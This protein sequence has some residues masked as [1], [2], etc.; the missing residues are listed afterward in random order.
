MRSKR[1]FSQYTA[2]F[3]ILLCA[4]VLVFSGITSTDDEQL[5]VVITENLAFGKDYSA[6]PLFGND[7]LQGKAGGVEPLHPII[8]IPLY[9]LADHFSLG[10]VQILY[11]LPALTTALTGALLVCIAKQK[12]AP[13]KTAAV[14]GLSY[15]LGT[16]ALPYARMNFREPLAALL[17]TT[18]VLFLE[19]GKNGQDHIWKRILYP[20]LSLISLGL[21]ALTKI[22]A[23]VLIPF[24]ILSYLTQK[25]IWKKEGRA[26]M[27]T[28]GLIGMMLLILAG[29][30]L[31][32]IL[33]ADS[34][35]RFTLRF[36]NYIRYTLPRLPHDHFWLAVAGLLFSPGKGLFIY[37]PMLI[38]S[39][40][41]PFLKRTK[42]VDWVT[43][44]SALLGLTAVQ[45]LIYNDQWWGITWGTRAHIP[46]LPLTALAALPALDAGLNHSN[47]KIRFGMISLLILGGCVQIGRLLVSDPVYANW[48]VQS[49]SRE[50][51]A[52]TQWN[53]H[54]MP[55]HR[56]WWLAL[57]GQ[58]SDIAWL[59]IS[60]SG[61]WLVIT[62]I[63]L[64]LIGISLGITL[65]TKK[66]KRQ[67]YQIIVALVGVF[68]LLLTPVSA[69]LDQR[70]Y[71]SV[72]AFEDAASEVCAVAESGDLVLIDAYLKPFWWFYINF[73][74]SGP[75][76]VGLPYIH[77]TAISGE[78][79]Y[80]RTAEIALL[81]RGRLD[82]SNQVFLIQSPHD[83]FLSYSDK[84]EKLGFTLV[85][86]ITLRKNILEF[87]I[88]K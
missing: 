67:P 79:F 50:I 88:I 81:I 53:L 63:L 56:H 12:G 11:L 77:D 8:G 61:I 37:S 85:P 39:L 17:I 3:L 25:H 4:Y 26:R 45:A 10:K 22:T 24:F 41:S 35:S 74:C 16:I 9:I 52:I 43:L 73:G 29:A 19:L 6:L 7:R 21:T 60:G 23:G 33:P 15:G 54:L 13:P 46:A 75:E 65:L 47:R 57:N 31:W 27:V 1:N 68:L 38:L 44:M 51:S 86:K 34:L 48:L 69:R 66:E 82:D 32:F 70:Y 42:P 14:L 18:A 84:F 49:T 58:P 59:H 80:P 36:F 64:A 76:W 5:F 87:I 2:V 40:V 72:P 83:N 71:G 30:I 20:F 78:Q 28:I 55:L 62:V